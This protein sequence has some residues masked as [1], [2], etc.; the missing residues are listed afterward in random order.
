MRF[1]KR[2]DDIGK[3]YVY[4]DLEG[5]EIPNVDLDIEPL[6]CFR[7]ETYAVLKAGSD[8][9]EWNVVFSL[10]HRFFDTMTPEEL[11]KFAAMIIYMHYEILLNMGGDQDL[12]GVV[13]TALEARLSKLLAEY[14]LETNL[15]NRLVEFTQI[16]VPIQLF[17]GVGERAQDTAEM[18]FYR[19]DVVKLTAVF[20]L[21]KMMT[22]ILGIFIE[23]CKKRMDNAY[24][25]IH[26]VAILKN[27]IANRM[28]PLI[29][30]LQNFI[31]RIIK[32]M[33]NNKVN[34]THIYNGFTFSTILQQIWGSM[35]TRRSIAVDLEKPNGNLITYVTSCA[36]AAAQTQF[37][38]T[39]FKTAVAEI[40]SPK[41]QA[42]E[43]DGNVS[44][45]EA[46]SKS[47][48]K[49]SD[50]SLL[51]KA[52]VSQLSIRFVSE[53]SLDRDMIAAASAYYYTNHVSLTPC[54]SYLLGTLFDSY[55]CGAKSVEMLSGLD[56]NILIPIMQAYF[57]QQGYY[58]IV[59]AV[60]V[61]P[62]GT[63][64]SFLTGS[65]TQL[66]SSWNSSFEYRNCDA[67]LPYCVGDLR[68]DT[69]LKD[70]VENFTSEILMFNTAPVFWEAL[71]DTPKN[72]ELF[73]APDSLAKT[74]CA[75]IS[76]IISVQ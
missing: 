8:D 22:P 32:P 14:D 18:T 10:V 43:E 19:D 4:L 64:K 55:L 63:Q 53:H 26:A 58:D 20:L 17:N 51:I 50:F 7:I 42:S 25:E 34:L 45:L 62:T 30:K 15:M 24:K 69:G 29:D 38:S 6:K 57:I 71:Q 46:E 31:A 54:N 73:A 47:S 40:I 9:F 2:I 16:N 74:I 27:I 35:M 72:G 65:D 13:M 12:D 67:K 76:D 49:T 23:S 36:R 66:R 70:I 52:S 28:Q 1:V 48:T 61:V 41:D 11:R 59:H 56:L 3:A 68:W 44:T 33:L 37:S 39:G 75:L 5:L 21:C 60:S